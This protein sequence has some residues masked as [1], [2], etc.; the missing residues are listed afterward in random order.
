MARALV[1]GAAVERSSVAADPGSAVAVGAASVT[2]A[3]DRPSRVEITIQND[4]ATQIIYLRLGPGSAV[5]NTGIRLNAAGGS[6]TSNS[7]TGPVQA[8]ATGAATPALVTE[9]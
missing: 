6:W 8:I 4:H 5:V 9:V 7:Y 1:A 2:V 3:P